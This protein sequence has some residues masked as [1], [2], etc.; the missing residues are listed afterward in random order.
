MGASNETITNFRKLPDTVWLYRPSTGI[1]NCYSV[2][3]L[4][5]ISLFL[6]P[7]VCQI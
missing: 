6:I 3:Q 7:V 2:A 1:V 4:A 5:E